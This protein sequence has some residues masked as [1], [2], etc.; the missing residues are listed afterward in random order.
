MVFSFLIYV[1]SIA[2]TQ[3]LVCF[4]SSPFPL[5]FAMT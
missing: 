2:I 4:L 5:V 1:I 3:F